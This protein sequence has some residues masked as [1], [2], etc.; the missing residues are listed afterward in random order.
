MNYKNQQVLRFNVPALFVPSVVRGITNGSS[1][2]TGLVDFNEVSNRNLGTTSSFKY[3]PPGAAIRSTQQ[4]PIDYSQFHNHIFFQS[5]QVA[6]HIAFHKLIDQFPFDGTQ[7]EIE[8]FM[9]SLTGFEKYIY[10]QFPK[11]KNFLYFSGV[12]GSS[13]SGT[14]IEVKDF[15]GVVYPEIS[16]N[17]TGN[18]I[19]NPGLNSIT[20]EF[21]LF[22]PSGTNDN[23]VVLQ[24][25][26][27][28]N[29]GISV[30]VSQSNSVSSSVVH[31]RN[32]S[33]SSY[34]EASATITKGIFN[35]VVATLN[36][37]P[38]YNRAELYVNKTL[39]D[40]S[41][42]SIEFGEIDF[43]L[44]SLFIGSGSS[45]N[46][47]SVFTPQQTLSGAMDELRVFH[48][49][50]TI[51]QQKSYSKKSIF[52]QDELKLYFKFN[53]PSGVYGPSTGSAVNRTVLDYSGNSL[54]SLINENGF[55]FN[56]R[57][58]GSLSNPMTYEKL[59]ESI[60]LFPNDGRI[61]ILNSDLIYSGSF[62]DQNNPNL[63]TKLIPPHFLLEGQLEE[64]FLTPEGTIV[65]LYSG[66]SIPGSG[67]I[68]Q[69]QIIQTLLYTW[70]KSFD[71]L[72]IILDSF[73]KV[74]YVDYD[75]NNT[76]PDQFLIKL[77]EYY[78][79]TLPNL[80]NNSSIEQFID[81][82]NFSSDFSTSEESLQFIQNQI[83]RRILVNINDIVKSKGTIHSVK[84]FIR[85]LGIDP[86]SNF[87]IREYGGINK[88]NLKNQYEIRTEVSSMLDMSGTNSYI[89][90]NILSSSRKEIGFPT[91]NGTMV[92]TTNFPP[93][94][95]S[96]QT[97]DGLLT[98]GSF[99]VEGIYKFPISSTL[100]SVT[101][102][103]FRINS[104]T[105]S[106]G[107]LFLN[108]SQGLLMNCVAIS[109]SITGTESVSDGRLQLF[110]RSDL[111]TTAGAQLLKL[112]LTGVNIFDGKKWN[113][114]AG[115]FRNDDPLDFLEDVN[116]V[117]SNVSSTYFI[118]AA[119][120][121]YGNIKE[122][123]TTQ[124]FFWSTTDVFKTLDTTNNSSGSV[125]YVGSQSLSI[126]SSS[127][128][129]FL[130]NNQFSP[131]NSSR[132]VRF[133]GKL[134]QLR[135]WSKGLLLDEWKEH[136]KNFKSLGTKTPLSNFNFKTAPTGSFGRLRLDISTDQVVT[137]SNSSGN[138]TLFD[139]S[140][141][142]L[143][144][145]GSGFEIS[146]QI[147]KPETFYYSHISPKFDEFS[148]NNKI[149]PRSF[150]NYQKSLDYNV[151]YGEVYE[152]NRNELPTDD[153]RF[154]I[155]FSIIDSLNQDIINIFST[156]E[157]I[158]NSIGYPES[159][160]SR[161][162]KGLLNLR[163]VYFNRLT[164]KINL[165]SFFEFFKWFDTNIGNFISALLPRKT[166]FRGVNF[167]IES[168]MLERNKYEHKNY[169]S[170]FTYDE[171]SMIKG[172]N[173]MK[174]IEGFISKY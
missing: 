92:Q 64:A 29:N 69:T 84:A 47:S 140:Q 132:S 169:E 138:I 80:F 97:R 38:S 99:T 102:S 118:R 3:D 141:N 21:Q 103:L 109:G 161:E 34:L 172:F 88:N 43:N 52:A 42:N 104:L 143:H 144:M 23:Q 57:I 66:N 31:F 145:S 37:R 7:Q 113:I 136:V 96:N 108:S 54:H 174:I 81:K 89:V 15:A 165:K 163:D 51:E 98:S 93:H 73:S 39:I 173:E 164:D 133:N 50:R 78:G 61:N 95:I 82:E 106:N 111:G 18:S 79:I 128:H 58:S 75:Q 148:N 25:L 26:S 74:L 146:K 17:K 68:G 10:D 53:E 168:H 159:L 119:R 100:S 105:G 6:T 9:D 117:K 20:F 27:G 126:G 65:D 123:Y 49:I 77:A 48:D 150:L 135:F 87:R 19:L 11:S 85:T 101:Q 170:Y 71:E 91:Q 160:Y 158:E 14:Y 41:E 55:N 149:R 155:D 45:M 137:S 121:E 134:S 72:K 59:S 67:E 90:S 147:I 124:S 151:N 2:P 157:E 56:L 33:G 46:G 76:V 167:V 44:S 153:V 116:S 70:A 122:I 35:H 16:K 28:T 60:V 40:Q 154:S 130:N 171:K 156:L 112:E 152:L 36:R 127:N 83:W 4:I 110:V 107:V 24:K 125:L 32:M 162:Y 1:V 8:L 86:D 12:N 63:I 13:N 30:F 115:R 120:S 139:F 94:G 22:I 5:A 166:K 142:S 114:S 62:Y 129:R 131:D